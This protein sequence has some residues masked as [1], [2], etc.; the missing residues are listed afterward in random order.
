MVL[1]GGLNHHK[2]P[3]NCVELFRNLMSVFL[4]LYDTATPYKLDKLAYLKPVATTAD[5]SHATGFVLTDCL[6]LCKFIFSPSYHLI[7]LSQVYS[8]FFAAG[9]VLV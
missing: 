1:T 9:F 5:C 6:I 8:L 4:A 2:Q 3:S 7:W